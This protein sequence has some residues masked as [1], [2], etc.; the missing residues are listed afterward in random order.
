MECITETLEDC[1]DEAPDVINTY[2]RKK[3]GLSMMA[4][5]HTVPGIIMDVTKRILRTDSLVVDA[6]LG[7]GEAL[8]CYNMKLQDAATTKAQLDNDAFYQQMQIINGISGANDKAD[9][10]K[11]VF[12]PCCD[13]AQ[14][15]N[16]CG[17]CG[18][19]NCP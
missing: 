17:C 16:N 4:E 2:A 13:V 9:K 8:D 10:Y 1:C 18:E 7:Q 3:F 14:N 11:K 12:G 15:T 6:L 19:C 5:G